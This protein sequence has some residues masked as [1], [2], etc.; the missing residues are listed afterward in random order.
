M[1]AIVTITVATN[2]EQPGPDD[3]EHDTKVPRSVQ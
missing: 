2:C 1:N 3:H